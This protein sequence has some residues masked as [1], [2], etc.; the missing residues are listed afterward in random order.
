MTSDKVLIR[1]KSDKGFGSITPN[2][3]RT[4]QLQSAS[5]YSQP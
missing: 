2:L 5:V 4:G 1:F 3:L